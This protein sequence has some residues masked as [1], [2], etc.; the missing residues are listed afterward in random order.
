MVSSHACTPETRGREYRSRGGGGELSK[1][2]LSPETFGLLHFFVEKQ[3]L[4]LASFTDPSAD[5]FCIE[6]ILHLQKVCPRRLSHLP[7]RNMEAFRRIILRISSGRG[8]ELLVGKI[9]AFLHDRTEK[10]E[11]SLAGEMSDLS[12]FL[13]PVEILAAACANSNVEDRSRALIADTLT[14]S[15]MKASETCVETGVGQCTFNGDNLHWVSSQQHFMGKIAADVLLKHQ[16]SNNILYMTSC[17]RY[18]AASV[19]L[20]QNIVAQGG[21][22]HDS[23]RSTRQQAS[24]AFGV[25][26][27]HLPLDRVLCRFSVLLASRDLALST[28]CLD[29]F[30]AL[31][32]T[33]PKRYLTHCGMQVVSKVRRSP[34]SESDRWRLPSEW[35][36]LTMA[37]VND[38][39]IGRQADIFWPEDGRWYQAEISE[40]NHLRKKAS[41]CYLTTNE[42]EDVNLAEIIHK[43]HMRLLNAPEEAESLA[44]ADRK[45]SE[46]G[47]PSSAWGVAAALANTLHSEHDSAVIAAVCAAAALLQMPQ[48]GLLKEI[49]CMLQTT[50]YGAL[51][52]G[53][54]ELLERLALEQLSSLDEAAAACA[55]HLASTLMRD[56]PESRRESQDILRLVEGLHGVLPKWAWKR[57]LSSAVVSCIEELHRKGVPESQELA[58]R[59]SECLRQPHDPRGG[60][61]GTGAPSRLASPRLFLRSDFANVEPEER[62]QKIR[63][64]GGTPVLAER[65]GSE[66]PANK[67]MAAREIAFGS[68]KSFD[69]FCVDLTLWWTPEE[70][71]A[72]QQQQHTEAQQAAQS[73]RA[74]E[75]VSSPLTAGIPGTPATAAGTA[76]MPAV[77]N[78][79]ERAAGGAPAKA[80]N[81]P[82]AKPPRLVWTKA[83]HQ[84]FV[85]AVEKLGERKAVPKSIMQ[86][87][88]V[89]GLTRE[90]VKRHLHTY[91]Q[92]IKRQ[93]LKA[94]AA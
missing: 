15:Q 13:A 86:H 77:E 37:D 1:W 10:A 29:L 17:I 33:E 59:V 38:S 3:I 51:V 40:V 6:S 14:L 87:M 12:Q 92:C 85:E 72:A 83:L 27:A 50:W 42:T 70:T 21:L 93:R 31:C 16:V 30:A 45:G 58:R 41:V 24:R 39:L 73:L 11:V 80:N 90:Q 48:I 34:C 23:M 61:R 2:L 60:G 26:L 32:A 81:P 35:R 54:S 7:L 63:S 91:R 43:G 79:L 64:E 49:S 8:H 65:V 71:H 89:E 25:E 19:V 5:E 57:G 74:F 9:A 69:E 53:T 88:G 4:Q 67:L 75:A 94:A 66:S 36:P 56:C 55:L 62:L 22:R 82:A 68:L 28:A 20:H 44:P 46:P 84:R 78:P 52:S 76:A 47:T 18:L